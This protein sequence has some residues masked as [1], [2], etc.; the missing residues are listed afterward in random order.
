MAPHLRVVCFFLFLFFFF[1]GRAL[2]RLI[3]HKSP[4]G[5]KSITYD[6]FGLHESLMIETIYKHPLLTLLFPG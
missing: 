6:L 1:A 3:F 4:K 5:G 2:S